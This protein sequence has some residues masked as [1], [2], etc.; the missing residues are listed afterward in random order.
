MHRIFLQLFFCCC[1]CCCCCF[2]V[3]FVARSV[4]LGFKHFL[5]TTV[6]FQILFASHIYV[7]VYVYHL[8]V[9]RPTSVTMLRQQSHSLVVTHFT[10]KCPLI[11]FLKMFKI[12]QFPPLLLSLLCFSSPFLHHCPVFIGN[13]LVLPYLKIAVSTLP[14]GIEWL[15]KALEEN[16]EKLH[17]K[18]EKESAV[19]V[20]S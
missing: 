18:V 14:L 12:V 10:L 7:F 9:K 11:F 1:C 19:Q 8:A 13:A 6:L 17:A 3:F 15:L 2:H 16:Y 20:R 4:C 5:G